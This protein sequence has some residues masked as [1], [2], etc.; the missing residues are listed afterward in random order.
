MKKSTAIF[1]GII[2]VAAGVLLI[3]VQLDFIE[4]FNIFSWRYLWPVFMILL[5][6]MFHVQFFA[7]KAKSPGLLVPG[8][9]LLVYGCL[10]MY[11]AITGWSSAGYLWPVFLVGPG[12]GLMELK[13]FSR[14]REGSWIP[15]I[16]L[17]GLALFFFVKESFSSFS[18]AAAVA[19]IVIG[20]AII[21]A[22]FFEGK[23]GKGKK[24]EPKV[25]EDVDMDRTL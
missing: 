4:N 17:F 11:M 10:F 23:K 1:W 20:V 21:I 3:L 16:I 14:G 6:L 9:I 22:A 18:I 15:V 5:G 12:F 8:G 2:L 7:G 24:N 25:E 13:L 19:L